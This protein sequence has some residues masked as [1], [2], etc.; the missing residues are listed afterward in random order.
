MSLIHQMKTDDDSCP[1]N[2]T[3]KTWPKKQKEQDLLD[4]L[5]KGVDHLKKYSTKLSNA[6]KAEYKNY[7][8]RVASELIERL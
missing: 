8:I 7:L 6:S 3:D 2:V 5:A 4:E 1:V